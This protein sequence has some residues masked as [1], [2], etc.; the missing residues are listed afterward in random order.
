M[1]TVLEQDQDC[2]LLVE[3]LA[4][5][6][7]AAQRVLAGKSDEEKATALRLAA[8]SLR[9]AADDVLAANLLDEPIDNIDVSFLAVMF[10]KRV[11]YKSAPYEY[12]HSVVMSSRAE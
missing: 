11:N 2:T 5:A 10:G 9:D 6:G 1:A 4:R 7:R 3:R 12:P 8:Q